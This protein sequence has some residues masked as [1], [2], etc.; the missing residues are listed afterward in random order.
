MK[1]FSKKICPYCKKEFIVDKRRKNQKYCCRKCSDLSKIGTKLPI[2]VREKI[3]MNNSKYWLGK[4]RGP[5][6]EETREKHRIARAK[7]IITKEHK[8]KIAEGR[9]GSKNWMW[10]GGITSENDK[11][12]KSRQYELWRNYCFERD[13]FTCQISGNSGGN[14]VVHHINNFSDFPELRLVI[15]NGIT[16][17]EELHKEF[18]HI[19]GVK[20]NTEEQLNEFIKTYDKRRNIK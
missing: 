7:Q 18:H 14:L 12:R 11:V 6:S 15:N 17:C 16:L 1:E 4:K 9:M 19:Y 2:Y 8:I 20:N 3:S 13:N 5:I 10:K